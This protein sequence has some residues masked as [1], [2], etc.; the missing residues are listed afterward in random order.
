MKAYAA[1]KLKKQGG[2]APS[3]EAA[4]RFLRRWMQTMTGFRAK[5]ITMMWERQQ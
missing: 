3:S 2:D 5:Q 4:R 1:G